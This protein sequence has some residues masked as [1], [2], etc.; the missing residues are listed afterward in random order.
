VREK[1]AKP[2]F[3]DEV[4]LSLDAASHIP[5]KLR[6]KI[7]HTLDDMEAPAFVR[8]VLGALLYSTDP[9]RGFQS[10]ASAFVLQHC[11]GNRE[12]TWLSIQLIKRAIR[13]LI[14]TYRIPVGS[15]QGA[16]RGYYFILN[17]VMADTATRPIVAQIR[18]LLR[19]VTSLA[20]HAPAVK[21]LTGKL[22]A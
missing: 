15:S 9:A 3:R 17:A 7:Q 14:E 6:G 10:P 4:Q 5:A 11:L 13:E 18:G 8:A 19:H 16:A 2:T 22:E 20:P 21:A 1:Q 12:S